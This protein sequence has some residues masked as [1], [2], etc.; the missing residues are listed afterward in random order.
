VDLSLTCHVSCSFPS[1]SCPC[2]PPRSREFSRLYLV[3]SRH[4]STRCPPQ[5]RTMNLRLLNQLMTGRHFSRPHSP[6]SSLYSTPIKLSEPLFPS[7]DPQDLSR[8][9]KTLKILKTS[10]AACPLHLKK[11]DAM[12]HSLPPSTHS[13]FSQV[14]QVLMY[15]LAPDSLGFRRY[16][17]SVCLVAWGVPSCGCGV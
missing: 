3:A 7:Q 6:S 14:L 5:C 2:R 16:D 13:C 10:R 12:H 17:V 9:L 1:L 11:Q 15:S 8:P 4:G